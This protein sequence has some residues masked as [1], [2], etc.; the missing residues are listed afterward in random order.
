MQVFQ[1]WFLTI[2]MSMIHVLAHIC[3][4]MIKF[5]KNSDSYTYS[6]SVLIY[7]V[8]LSHCCSAQ[9][10]NHLYDMFTHFSSN[11]ETRCDSSLTSFAIWYSVQ[12]KAVSFIVSVVKCFQRFVVRL[13]IS[14]PRAAAH[15]IKRF[16][17]Q[18]FPNSFRK[19]LL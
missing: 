11:M 14:R 8:S 5:I 12:T 6:P 3:S 16:K 4:L 13:T 17:M 10:F 7:S 1:S 19:R 18:D 9:C 15:W 2:C